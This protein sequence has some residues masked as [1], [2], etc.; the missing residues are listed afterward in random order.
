MRF[1]SIDPGYDK[2]GIAIVEGTANNPTLVFSKCFRTDRGDSHA[3]R[4]K[5]ISAE[6]SRTIKQFR[7]NTLAIESLLF[8]VNKKT[9]I[10]VAEARGVILSVASQNNLDVVEIAP[11]TIKVA[12]TGY[13]S[14]TKKQVVFMIPRLL[15]IKL[16]EKKEDDEFDAIAI[17]ITAICL[18]KGARC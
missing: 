2:L 10:K 16:S 1:L 12:I 4:L 17:G 15:K 11:Q 5:Y 18:N 9:A 6:I 7:P 13:G 14:A 3:D 8:S